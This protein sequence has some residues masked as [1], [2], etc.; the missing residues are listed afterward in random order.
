MKLFDAIDTPKQLYLI[1]E[2]IEGKMLHNVLKGEPGKRLHADIVAKIFK[3]IVSGMAKYHTMFIAHRDL[4][5]EN[6]LV[7]MDCPNYTTKIIDFGFAAKSKE[8]M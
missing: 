7:N 1:T 2:H 3:Q 5:P 8:K 6:I 4:K